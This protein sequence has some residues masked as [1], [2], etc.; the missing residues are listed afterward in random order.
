M[1]KL[2]VANMKMNLNKQEIDSYLKEIE[3]KDLSNVIF[4]PTSIYI[5]YFLKKNLTVGIQNISRFINGS[6]TGQISI[7]QISSLKI[8]Y[9]IIGHSETKN[10]ID[11]IHDKVKL[12]SEH[13]IIPIICIGEKEDTKLEIKEKILEEQLDIIL[14]DIKLDKVIIAYEPVWMIGSNKNIDTFTLHHISNFLK[15][16]VKK[17]KMNDIMLLYGGSVNRLN[18]KEILSIDSIDGVLVG[19]ASLDVYQLL[20]MIEVA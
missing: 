5:P 17:Y 18:I 3:N 11:E 7:K 1:N 13:N 19:N 9:A 20:E 14:K 2:I 16:L 4:C 6:H 15:N 8:K 12:C 10:E